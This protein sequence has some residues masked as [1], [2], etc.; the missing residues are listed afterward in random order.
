MLIVGVGCGWRGVGYY[1]FVAYLIGLDS[2]A[3]DCL[4]S[5]LMCF[6]CFKCWFAI[7]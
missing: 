3:Y 6:V 1:G 7:R 5:G 4:I 2:G